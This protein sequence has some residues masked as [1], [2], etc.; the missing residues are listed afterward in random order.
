MEAPWF[1]DWNWYRVTDPRNA[2]RSEKSWNTG[3]PN[4]IIGMS[5]KAS[6][7][8]EIFIGMP[9]KASEVREIID[10]WHIDH[11]F[12]LKLQIYFFSPN[13]GMENAQLHLGGSNNWT[14]MDVLILHNDTTKAS[15]SFTPLMEWFPQPFLVG[16]S[17]GSNRVD[18]LEHSMAT[19]LD[20][21]S[22][23]PHKSRHAGVMCRF[24]HSVDL[25]KI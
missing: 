23:A 1:D 3:E 25:R 20:L 11:R 10:Y 13:A 7:V 6:E 17:M 19:C 12:L 24:V 21:K 15:W 4:L 2:P 5:L 18:L 8:R 16:H 9:L 14:N 22:E